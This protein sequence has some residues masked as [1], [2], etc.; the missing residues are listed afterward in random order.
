MAESRSAHEATLIPFHS[1]H[2]CSAAACVAA[3]A[4][5]DVNDRSVFGL[6]VCVLPMN[7][8]VLQMRLKKQLSGGRAPHLL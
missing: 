3:A 7:E 5:V 4:H 2:Y 1:V 6:A 8:P